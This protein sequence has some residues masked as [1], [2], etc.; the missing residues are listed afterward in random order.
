MQSVSLF[1]EQFLKIIIDIPKISQDEVIDRY[2]KR[3]EARY[4]KK[5]C[6]T[7]Y[8]SL[9]TLM[10]DALN[11][12]AAKNSF[13]RSHTKSLP[14]S[15]YYG[16]RNEMYKKAVNNGPVPMYV[17]KANLEYKRKQREENFR[18]GSC[19]YCHK[20]RELKYRH[21]TRNYDQT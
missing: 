7:A 19:F 20:E 16:Q 12:E 17:S 13:S 5:I 4:F 8:K 18:N 9:T 1:H 11:I 6:T 3:I 21:R 2:F 10:S 15:R 14:A